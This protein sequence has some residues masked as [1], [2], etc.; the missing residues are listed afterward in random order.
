MFPRQGSSTLLFLELLLPGWERRY[1]PHV[2]RE[3]IDQIKC[4][5]EHFVPRLQIEQTPP[6]TQHHHPSVH[7]SY[8]PRLW[9]LPRHSEREGF[10]D[11]RIESVVPQP[12]RPLDHRRTSWFCI[13][14]ILNGSQYLYSVSGF[15]INSSVFTLE[16][17]PTTT[18]ETTSPWTTPLGVPESYV[19]GLVLVGV[20]YLV[21]GV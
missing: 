13:F 14:P 16:G 15:T 11:H 1:C 21:S 12:T 5:L 7:T 6:P 9:H 20:F 8:R 2:S 10:G 19:H 3:T 17:G 18:P 4:S